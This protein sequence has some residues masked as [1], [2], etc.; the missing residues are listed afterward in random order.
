MLIGTDSIRSIGDPSV[1]LRIGL[2]RIFNSKQTKSFLENILQETN[3]GLE[4]LDEY[5]L[6]PISSFYEQVGGL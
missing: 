6:V 4:G 5:Q 1:K 3:A 2:I